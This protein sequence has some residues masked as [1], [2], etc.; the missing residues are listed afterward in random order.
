MAEPARIV[1]EEQAPPLREGERMDQPT[2]HALY[3]GSPPD[4]R[5][6]LIGGVVHVMSPVSQDHSG[7]SFTLAWWLGAY[8]LSTPGVFGR[9]E[10]TVILGEQSEPQP[11]V[12][13]FIGPA[14]GG[15]VTM[16]GR[17]L[18][19]APE[20]IVEVSMTT[21][22]TDLGPKQRD[23]LEAGVEEYLVIL[24]NEVRWFRLVDGEYQLIP[25]DEDGVLRSR[26]LPGLWLD[27]A[28]LLRDDQQR[29]SEVLE[30]G[31]ASPDHADFVADLTQQGAGA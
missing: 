30:Q 16:D 2:F 21:A 23:Y 28:A 12:Y 10:G 1:T 29:L 31:L 6:E 3:L 4:F 17:Y 27:P 24:E 18:R 25:E 19:G 22:A 15:K 7:A 20:L 8:R 5:A 11:D 26:R 14:H 13:L 9:S